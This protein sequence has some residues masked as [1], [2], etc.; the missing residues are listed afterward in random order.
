MALDGK[1]YGMS[2]RAGF[3]TI[4]DTKDGTCENLEI[5][6]EYTMKISK[7]CVINSLIYVFYHDLEL[8]WY[9]SKEKIWKRV[10]VAKFALYSLN[11]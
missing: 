6:H 7:A 4:Y 11:S 10:N 9:D 3:H 5:P 1:V 2:F 8:M